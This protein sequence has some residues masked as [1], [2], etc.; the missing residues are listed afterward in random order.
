VK[1]GIEIS[2]NPPGKRVASLNVLS[3]GERTL[4]SLA[5]LFAILSINP[6]PFC[7]LDEVDA[8]LDEAN[9]IRFTKI[10]DDLSG[11]TQFI[12]ISH[13]RDTMKAADTL[14]GVTMDDDHISKLIS[15]R[16]A[17]ALETAK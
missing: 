10:L 11:K 3:G 5:L 2:A 15:V 12:I 14:Y 1:S 9:T 8:A 13:N 6:S 17:E 7:F 16:L 4:T